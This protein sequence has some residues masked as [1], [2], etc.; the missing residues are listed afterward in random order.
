MDFTPRYHKHGN[1]PITHINHVQKMVEILWPN[2]NSS[3]KEPYFMSNPAV[4]QNLTNNIFNCKSGS[5]DPVPTPEMALPSPDSAQNVSETFMAGNGTFCVLPFN[6]ESQDNITTCDIYSGYGD[7]PSCETMNGSHI[8]TFVV[9]VLMRTTFQ[10]A[11]NIAFSVMDGTAMTY[12]KTYNG[13]YAMCLFFQAIGG[14]IASFLGG[15]LVQDSSDPS[16]L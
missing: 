5:G 15:A 4:Y 10:V 7:L 6:G 1:H 13:E 8:T 11:L 9:Y 14:F 2:C 12:C 3:C 16:G